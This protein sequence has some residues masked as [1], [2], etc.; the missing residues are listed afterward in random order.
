MRK[1]DIWLKKLNR[2][3]TNS[4]KLDKVLNFKKNFQSKKILKNSN[5]PLKIPISFLKGIKNKNFQDPIF[6]QFIPNIK[7]KRNYKNIIKDPILGKKNSVPG[8][9][10]KYKNRILLILNKECAIHCRYCFRKNFTYKN[11]TINL[12]NFHLIIEYIQ[13]NRNINEVIFSGGDPLIEKDEKIRI[14]IKLL[15]N[16]PQIKILRVHSRF[17]TIIPE[18]ITE[19]L[20]KIFSSSRLIICFVTHINHPKEI[21]KKVIK[22]IKKLKESNVRLFNQSVLLKGINDEVSILK[23]LSYKLF[24]I[25]IVPYYIHML[26]LVEGTKHF[27]V[28]EKIAKKIIKK[29]SQEI[30]G[31]LLPRLVRELP[32]YLSKVFLNF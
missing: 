17:P 18:R 31:Y 11:N 6:R 8:L 2:Q 28:E 27:L 29:L 3:I 20:C 30:S 24:E 23:N 9:L 19:E 5:F 32:G 26:D 16:I 13:K 10:H 22:Y 15:E 1:K 7:E 4:K 14:F 21:N 12:K 25:G